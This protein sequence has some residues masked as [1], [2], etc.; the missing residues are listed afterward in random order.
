MIKEFKVS[1]KHNNILNKLP[2]ERIEEL[3]MYMRS[4]VLENKL[5]LDF[6]TAMCAWSK[7]YPDYVFYFLLHEEFGMSALY[8]HNGGMQI[9]DV[10]IKVSKFN[11]TA[12]LI[13]D[14]F[15]TIPNL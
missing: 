3:Y 2:K 14:K 13:P 12:L 10:K 9:A 11:E 8:F 4:E 15:Y 1:K 6:Q 5:V 7:Y